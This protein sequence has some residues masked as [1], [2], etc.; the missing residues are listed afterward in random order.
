MSAS[1]TTKPQKAAREN[2]AVEKGA[3]FLFH[4]MGDRAIPL[5]LSAQECFQLLRNDL[6]Q[7]GCFGIPGNVIRRSIAHGERQCMPQTTSLGCGFTRINASASSKSLRLRDNCD[8]VFP[9][10][11]DFHGRISRR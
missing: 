5:L 1:L 10:F 6:V 3:K 7:H 8:P 2:T 9:A 4:E 11:G